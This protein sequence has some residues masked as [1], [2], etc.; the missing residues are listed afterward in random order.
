MDDRSMIA[1]TA[2]AAGGHRCNNGD[3][4][5]VALERRWTD[6]EYILKRNL[7]RFEE[8]YFAGDAFPQIWLNLGASGHAAFF[9]GAKYGFDDSTIWFERS[10]GDGP[11]SD[12][13]PPEVEFDPEAPLYRATLDLA[14]YL[15]DEARGRFFVSMPDTSGNLDA[16]AHL[17]GSEGVL[18][19]MISRPE[20]VH[21]ELVRVQE[22]WRRTVESVY[23]ITHENND[24]G[25]TIGWLNTWA[26]GRHAQM[27]CDLSVMISPECFREFAVPELDA[28]IDW[29][30]HSL[31]H[32]DGIDQARHLDA[33]LDL[34]GL[35][36]IQFTCVA[37]Q[38]SPVHYLPLL[39]RIQNAGK[40][41]LIPLYEGAEQEEIITLLQELS[42]KGLM[43]I[44]RADSVEEADA[45]VSLA[46]RYTHE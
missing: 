5:A 44:A 11:M 22:A 12:D 14:R 29:M 39:K 26:P 31:Y 16:L 15:A 28:Q 8:T 9:S 7:Q 40:S 45:I 32:F 42:S 24:G 34:D 46:G 20:W 37:G 21:R 25:S 41:L 43:L 1:V 36:A 35:D 2:P 18:T 30:D 27:Q 13:D 4:P 3:E 17:R 6:G 19:D 33:L 23:Q 10:L 38:P